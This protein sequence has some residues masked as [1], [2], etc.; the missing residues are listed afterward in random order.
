MWREQRELPDSLYQGNSHE[1]A[2]DEFEN[3]AKEDAHETTPAC[4]EGVVE[5]FTADQFAKTPIVL[6]HTPHFVPP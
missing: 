3:R 5:G 4:F 1:T 2:G 6:P